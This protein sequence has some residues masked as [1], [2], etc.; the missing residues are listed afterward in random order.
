[1]DGGSPVG[2]NFNASGASGGGGSGPGGGPVK[3]VVAMSSNS[4]Q[5][6]VV[7]SEGQYYVFNIDLENGGEGTLTKQFNVLDSGGERNGSDFGGSPK[8]RGDSFRASLSD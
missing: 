5:V 3:T 2:G 8:R 4:P 1:M 7:T 6:M